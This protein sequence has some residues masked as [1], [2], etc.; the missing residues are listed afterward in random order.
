MYFV[1]AGTFLFSFHVKPEK[2]TIFTSWQIFLVFSNKNCFLR[3]A[4]RK[5]PRGSASQYN[6]SRC[7]TP[8]KRLQSTALRFFRLIPKISQ[9]RKVRRCWKTLPYYIDP[10]IN[11]EAEKGPRAL[12]TGLGSIRLSGCYSLSSYMWGLPPPRVWS[13]HSYYWRPF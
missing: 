7:S 8:A 4:T 13:A 9:C 11:I 3:E 10:R 6:V 1:T 2:M 12:N 5:L